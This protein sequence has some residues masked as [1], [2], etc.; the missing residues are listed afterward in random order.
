MDFLDPAV[1]QRVVGKFLLC[2]SFCTTLLV[3]LPEPG[4]MLSNRLIRRNFAFK[5]MVGRLGRDFAS[6]VVYVHKNTAW[7]NSLN[8]NETRSKVIR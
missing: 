2:K 4:R 7:Y 8:K 3:E 1:V 5:K 6:E